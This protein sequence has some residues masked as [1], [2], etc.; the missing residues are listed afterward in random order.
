MKSCICFR[1]SCHVHWDCL[2]H[3]LVERVAS[4]L[5]VCLWLSNLISRHCN[6][7]LV[8]GM[9][10]LHISVVLCVCVHIHVYVLICASLHIHVSVQF[11]LPFA[12]RLVT[13]Q[14]SYGRT[15]ARE[16]LVRNYLQHPTHKL[17]NKNKRAMRCLGK[18]RFLILL[19]TVTYIS[20]FCCLEIS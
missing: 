10:M 5:Q 4:S 7:T 2:S 9:A 16:P 13:E 19:G 3:K 12:F 14:I 1:Y 17:Q 20:M 18:S 15:W 6:N 11:M 8:T